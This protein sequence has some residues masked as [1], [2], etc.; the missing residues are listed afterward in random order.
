MRFNPPHR[1]SCGPI[2]RLNGR[3]SIVRRG[4]D[5]VR[6]RTRLAPAIAGFVLLFCTGTEAGAQS[7]VTEDLRV[8]M[9]AAGPAGLEAVMIRPADSA[10]HPLVLVSHGSPR[11]AE[12]RPDMSARS[13]IPQL[14][15]FAKRGFVAVGV[16]RRGYGTS[17]GG[18]AESY[19]PCKKPDY[20][21]AGRAGA[22]DLKASLEFLSRRADVDP[23][24][25]LAVGISAGGFATVALTAD[26]PAGL[27][28]A[29]SFA[30]GRGSSGP[31]ETCSPATLIQALAVFGARS[32]VP[33]LWVYA[34][35]D[36]FFDPSL[37]ARMFEAF[38]RAGGRASLVRAP[39][40]GTDGHQLFSA[41][42]QAIWTPIVDDF[43]AAHNLPTA[44]APVVGRPA[45][46]PPRQLGQHALH[47]FE[48]FLDAPSHKAFAVSAKGAYAWRT[49]R[50]TTAEASETALRQCEQI[51]H[52]PCRLYAVDD[53][54][55]P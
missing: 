1:Q 52:Q 2:A 49:A 31:D 51:G 4:I 55:A 23:A 42:G 20:V 11:D 38:T 25:M 8:P 28:A 53:V 9:T 30:G 43:L 46:A 10:R 48:T 21:K 35:N 14:V 6:H 39:A 13:M 17:P 37:A 36:H 54:Y 34:E 18:W 47:D 40:Y 12:A 29:I 50:G 19:G 5:R 16:L 26:P 32:R 45:L 27:V 7:L 22:A 15:E 3:M 41:G 24:R 44:K 33:T